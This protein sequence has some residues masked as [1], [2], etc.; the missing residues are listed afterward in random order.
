MNH[1]KAWVEGIIAV[2]DDASLEVQLPTIRE[3]VRGVL[4]FYEELEKLEEPTEEQLAALRAAMKSSE[5]NYMMERAP[6]AMHH[7]ESLPPEIR[8]EIRSEIAPLVEAMPRFEKWER[9]LGEHV[10][11]GGE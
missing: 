1:Q 2:T 4:G 10:H 9:L 7:M 8:D 3:G 11:D 5:S 6:V